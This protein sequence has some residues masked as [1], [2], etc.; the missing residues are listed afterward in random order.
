MFNAFHSIQESYL[1]MQVAISDPVVAGLSCTCRLPHPS[2][3]VLALL[4]WLVDERETYAPR[5]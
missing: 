1:E 2:L 5:V 4:T 3:R